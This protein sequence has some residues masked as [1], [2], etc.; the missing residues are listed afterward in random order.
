VPTGN[1]QAAWNTIM[2]AIANVATA[3]NLS[4]TQPNNSKN[5]ST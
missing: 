3:T 4:D 1:P 2:H 5:E